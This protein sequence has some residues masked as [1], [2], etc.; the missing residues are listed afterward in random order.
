MPFADPWPMASH[1]FGA[2]HPSEGLRSSEAAV[3]AGPATGQGLGA[4][5]TG[6]TGLEVWL[7]SSP[8]HGRDSVSMAD[9]DE[10]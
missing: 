7:K 6:S 2:G 8:K 9:E 5:P 10:D 1:G 4:T 3:A